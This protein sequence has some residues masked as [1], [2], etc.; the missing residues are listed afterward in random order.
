MSSEALIITYPVAALSPA[1]AS[2]NKRLSST[3]NSVRIRVNCSGFNF[4]GPLMSNPI[5]SRKK[6]ALGLFLILL[7]S[8]FVPVLGQAPSNFDKQRGQMMLKQIQEDVRKNYYDPQFH[9]MD[10]DARFKTAEEKIKQAQSLGQIMGTIAQV[11]VE[12]DDSHTFFLPP[13]FNSKTE[14]GWQMQM[15]GEK[16]FVTAVKPG[17]DAAAKGLAEGDEIYALD[18]RAV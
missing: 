1:I 12:L 8:M 15:V 9:G 3:T 18:G 6:L 5:N 2:Q 11:L 17:S 7:T 13:G 14:Y 10:L 16:C 4:G